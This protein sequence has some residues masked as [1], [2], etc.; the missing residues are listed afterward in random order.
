MASLRRVSWSTIAAA[1]VAAFWLLSGVWAFVSPR[2]FYDELAT[3]P[4]YN[5]H[6]IHDV[7]AL[8]IGLGAV[9]GFTVA[10]LSAWRAALLGVGVGS[11]VHVVSHVVDYDIGGSV[12]D[13][14]G[15][16]VVTVVTIAAAFAEPGRRQAGRAAGEPA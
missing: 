6:F 1:V 15:L 8:S 16:I 4:P 5:V 10:G 9:L 12:T 7:G 11:A 13:I 3:F 14:V 2:S